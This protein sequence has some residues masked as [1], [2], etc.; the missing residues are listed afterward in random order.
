MICGSIARSLGR[1]MRVGQLSMMAGAMALRLDVG[2]AL[3]GEDDRGVLLPQRLQPFAELRGEAAIVER[4][5]AFV[6]DE[7]GGPTVETP[8]DAVEEIG[9]DGRRRARADQ[10]LGLEGLHVG[11]AQALGL[12]VEQPAVG[13]AD[14]VG[15]ERLLQRRG[16]QQD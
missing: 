15:F 2:E 6:D 5:P 3:G 11:F 9:E 10:A 4:Q 1:K 13:P 16:L 12:G 7:Q 14:A 8:L